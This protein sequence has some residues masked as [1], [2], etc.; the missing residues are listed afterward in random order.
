MLLVLETFVREHFWDGISTVTQ[1]TVQQLGK[2][3][4]SLGV[5]S[6][7]LACNWV[8]QHNYGSIYTGQDCICM[9][10][11]LGIFTLF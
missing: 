7:E 6:W 1:N 8:Y 11:L 10:S 2:L 3:Y 4:P 9:G 5:P